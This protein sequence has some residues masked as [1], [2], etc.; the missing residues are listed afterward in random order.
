MTELADTPNLASSYCP[1]CSPERDPT[2]E[3]L[4]VRWCNAHQP[5]YEGFDDGQARVGTEILSVSGEAEGVTNRR[6]CALVHRRAS[7]S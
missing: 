5:R 2:R 6:W 4:T 3:I 1:G 7:H